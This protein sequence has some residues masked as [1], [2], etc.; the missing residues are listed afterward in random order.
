MAIADKFVVSEE[1]A[2]GLVNGIKVGGLWGRIGV[3]FLLYIPISL[4]IGMALNLPIP[5]G[6][7]NSAEVFV[8]FFGFFGFMLIPFILVELAVR[9]WRT[10]NDF[11]INANISEELKQREVN[12]YVAREKKAHQGFNN[13]TTDSK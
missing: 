10:K 8:K 9:S 12:V 3:Y 6:I 4:L 11:S 2:K 5:I 1:T 13:P 7:N